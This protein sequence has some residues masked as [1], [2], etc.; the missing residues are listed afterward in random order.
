[1]KFLFGC[2]VNVLVFPCMVVYW[3]SRLVLAPQRAFQDASQFFA[4]FPGL[5]GEFARRAFYR[6]VLPRC[7]KDSCLCFGTI[8]SHPTAE[9]GHRVYV[10][11]YCILG[12]VTLEDDVLLASGVSIANGTNQHGIE[13]LDIPI[14]EQ[15]GEFPHLTIGEDTWIG[16]RAIVLA[17][18]GRHCVVGAGSLVL[19]DLP[20]YA[21]AVGVPARIVKFRNQPDE[22]KTDDVK[23]DG[24]PQSAE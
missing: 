14:R 23:T 12:D 9:I 2:F 8:F 15:P 22:K 18:V 17:N 13:R 3:L 5:S 6:W 21:I 4:I 1:M 11:P 16:E 19:D 7:E 20:D 10:G 24:A